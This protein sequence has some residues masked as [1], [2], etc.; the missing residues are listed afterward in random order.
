VNK[1]GKQAKKSP[2]IYGSKKFSAR[3]AEAKEDAPRIRRCGICRN[4]GH[5]ASRCAL[6]DVK[7]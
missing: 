4:P 6:L 1:T 3:N 5:Y 2:Y 7:R